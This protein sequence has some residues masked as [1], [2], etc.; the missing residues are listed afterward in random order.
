M[1]YYLEPKIISPTCLYSMKLS[2]SETF[3]ASPATIWS[4]L[5][6]TDKLA[7]ITPGLSR[8]ERTG[9][10]TYEAIADVK[11]GPVKGSFSGDMSIT[12]KEEPKHFTLN[13]LQKSKIGNVNAAVNIGLEPEGEGQ[14][15]L[16]FDGQAK[17]S[18]LLARTG[19]RVMTG[20][21]NS[22]TKQFF[23]NLSA[24]LTNA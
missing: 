18:G 6:D 8:L 14:T 2:G 22:L 17:M 23:D 5:M 10:D 11:V 9:E 19:G 24:E 4:I 7:G 12:D 21:A 15:K 13:I 16:S 1:I 3:A 20:V